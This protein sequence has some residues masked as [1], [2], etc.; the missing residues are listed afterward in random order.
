MFDVEEEGND[1]RTEKLMELAMLES[2]IKK[3]KAEGADKS[4]IQPKWEAYKKLAELLDW[5]IN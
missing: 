1:L 5:K 3:M 2:E 4:E